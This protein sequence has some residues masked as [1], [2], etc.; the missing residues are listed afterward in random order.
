MYNINEV[1]QIMRKYTDEFK[2]LVVQ[3][4][5]ES[6][7]SV[8]TIARKYGLPSKNYINNWENQLK[9]KGLLAEDTEKS[10]IK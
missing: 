10:N 4:Y 7:M 2:L 8:R 1:M 9:R 6:D 3:D 5:Y